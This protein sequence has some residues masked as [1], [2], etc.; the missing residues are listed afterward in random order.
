[1]CLILF[2]HDIH[3]DYRLILA[4][5]RDEFYARPA[6]AAAFWDEA[7]DLLAGRDLAGGGT[8][9][10]VTR[11]G[12]WAAVANV[13]D[14]SDQRQGTPS[15][16]RLVADFLRGGQAPLAFLAEAAARGDAYR[17]FNL[18]TGDADTLGYG[19]NRPG[20][21]RSLPPGLYGL[22]NAVLDTPWP[23]V[24]RG[25]AALSGLLTRPGPPDPQDLFA[26]LADT[27]RPPDALLPDTGVGLERERLLSPAFIA[28]PSY[29]TRASTVVLIGRGGKATFV[30]RSFDGAPDRW[31]EVRHDFRLPPAATPQ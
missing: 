11:C 13:R 9:L 7:P 29:G 6:A 23:K 16:G 18:L 27:T 2:A 15:R 22:S 4:A 14:P 30:E 1:M 8:W 19:S 28:S 10:G 24:V 20:E 31:S 25:K 17:G 21:A 26:L 12:R 3:P 5:N